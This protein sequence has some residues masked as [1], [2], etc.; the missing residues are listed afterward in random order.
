[1]TAEPGIQSSLERLL[2][3]IIAQRNLSPTIPLTWEFMLGGLDGNPNTNQQNRRGGPGSRPIGSYNP[4]GQAGESV[5]GGG[6]RPADEPGGPFLGRSKEN[7]DAIAGN[8]NS[9]NPSLGSNTPRQTSTPG[10][11]GKQ[12]ARQNQKP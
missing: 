1:V 11:K 10:A 12:D 2:F 4:G 5:Q 8:T 7:S 3:A 6:Q 9:G